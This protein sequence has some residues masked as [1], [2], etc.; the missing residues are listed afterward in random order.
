MS[1][2]GADDACPICLCSMDEG[3][4][5]PE[6]C[7][8]R[9][10]LDCLT[11]WLR[12]SCP[13][14]RAEF[15]SVY[16]Y[17][18]VE[19]KPALQKVEQMDPPAEAEPFEESTLL[20]F[21][22][23]EI[24]SG[25]THEDLLLM[26]DHCDKGCS[27]RVV[28]VSKVQ[29]VFLMTD[30]RGTPYNSQRNA[31]GTYTRRAKKR[32]ADESPDHDNLSGLEL[33]V[34][35]SNICNSQ[36]GQSAGIFSRSRFAIHLDSLLRTVVAYW[37]A[38][39]E[40]SV[41]DKI[42]KIIKDGLVEG[43]EKD[44]TSVAVTM[45]SLSVFLVAIGLISTSD[46]GPH[47]ASLFDDLVK[48]ARH[49]NVELLELLG[50]ALAV[51]VKSELTE[52]NKM[53]DQILNDNHRHPTDQLTPLKKAVDYELKALTKK[54]ECKKLLPQNA[55]KSKTTC[56]EA[57]ALIADSLLRMVMAYWE[58]VP[59]QSGKDKIEKII[60]DG[61]VEG[62]EKDLTSVTAE[63][64]SLQV[65][66]VAVGLL[67]ISDADTLPFFGELVKRASSQN[68]QVLV[69]LGEYLAKPVKPELTRASELLDKIMR[70]KKRQPVDQLIP[71]KGAAR[72]ELRA[73]GK[74]KEC[75]SRSKSAKKDN[76]ACKEAFALIADSLLRTVMA[77]REAVPDQS[78]K[79]N[80]EKIINDGLVKG[81]E[82]SLGKVIKMI[83]I[84]FLKSVESKDSE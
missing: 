51:P 77:Y 48:K 16:S 58:A 74:K 49:K 75:K 65:F 30:V 14:C 35:R 39:P 72:N 8:H 34:K 7:R 15:S 42:E 61:L 23:C 36:N 32:P 47:K 66:L 43:N 12:L 55:S 33:D 22:F 26:C 17:K 27:P 46:A 73:L 54:R 52:A 37:E 57:F 84:N 67:S 62:N 38:V 3:F 29:S 10:D 25:A 68:R 69:D 21:S 9:F 81:N 2:P 53:L 60:N 18:M 31:W 24:C 4:S 20:D 82:L 50:E 5:R 1:S 79:D 41:K 13:S 11:E 83:A 6:S 56:R 40:Q 70:Q 28:Q 44:V 71:L 64:V 59:E 19:G 45:V 63:M 78:V 80:I 76:K